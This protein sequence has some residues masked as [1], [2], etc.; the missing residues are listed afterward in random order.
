MA[1]LDN[2][3]T[4][5]RDESASYSNLDPDFGALGPARI[6]QPTQLDIQVK[7]HRTILNSGNYQIHTTPFEVNT[8]EYRGAILDLDGFLLNSERP[9]VRC[10]MLAAQELYRESTGISDARL[11]MS[12]VRRINKEA[13]G[14]ADTKMSLIVRSILSEEGALPERCRSISDD[15]FIGVYKDL[16]RGH[17][18]HLIDSGEFKELAGA[19]EFVKELSIKMGGKVSIYT[20]SP[21]ESA[22]LEISALGLDGYLPI[23]YRVYSSDLPSGKGKPEPDGFIRAKAKLGLSPHDRWISGGDRWKDFIGAM[24]AGGCGVFLTVAEN[25]DN[26]PFREAL[27]NAIAGKIELSPAALLQLEREKENLRER[28]ILLGSLE[29]KSVRIL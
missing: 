3:H 2:S 19:I 14:N 27:Q 18:K 25:L 12:I 16:R 22:D 6:P 24:A 23:E 21:K 17:F 11:A 29:R 8:S 28:L 13:L 5:S 1:N 7:I 26:Q 10:I 20:G 4:K 15:E 9:I